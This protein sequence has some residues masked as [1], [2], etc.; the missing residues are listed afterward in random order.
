MVGLGVG[1]AICGGM[2]SHRGTD[3]EL[4]SEVAAD[5]DA[6]R[7]G[8]VKLSSSSSTVSNNRFSTARLVPIPS[9][10]A[11]SRTDAR[12]VF[13]SRLYEGSRR[14]RRRDPTKAM[15]GCGEREGKKRRFGCCHYR[16]IFE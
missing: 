5:A 3:G 10:R 7:T 13:E 2:G 9:S 11:A 1:G 14:L 15:T 6:D 12:R 8:V 16:S 4:S